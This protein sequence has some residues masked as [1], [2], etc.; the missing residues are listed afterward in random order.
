VPPPFITAQALAFV[1]EPGEDRIAVLRGEDA[2]IVV[3][4]DGVGGLSGGKGAG[5][6][7]QAPVGP[8]SG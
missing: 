5:A 4:A 8:T 6:A 7:R 3:V 2:L 1:R